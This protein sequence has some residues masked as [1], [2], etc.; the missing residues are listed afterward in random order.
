MKRLFVWGFVVAVIA[1]II[2]LISAAGQTRTAEPSPSGISTAAPVTVTT[3]ATQDVDE[4]F[5][6]IG[7]IAANNDVQVVSETQGRIVKVFASV[8]DHV[9][10]GAVLVEVDSE[11]REAAYK[12]ARA[13]YEKARKDLDRN[14]AL[15]KEGSIA[16]SQIEQIRWA[17]QSAEG[18]YIVARRQYND[19]KITSPIA[20]V[21]TARPVDIGVMAA[22]GAVVANVVDISR[23]K[24]KV[25]VPEKDAFR[26]TVGE[27]VQIVTDVYPGVSFA[28]TIATIGAKGD[29]AHT[30]P[31]E[32]S[33]G[34][35][36]E[37]PLKAGMFARVTFNSRGRRSIVVPRDAIIGGVRNARVYVVQNNVAKLRPVVVGDEVGT[38]IQILSGLKE[39]DLVVVNGQ[40]NLKDNVTVV[41]RR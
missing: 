37:Q 24:V 33:M 38:S 12:T 39:G 4:R 32:I 18:Q 27:K 36:K 20:G 6:L 8:G 5:I 22:P 23:L 15:Y 26:L 1:T 19:T 41:V 21:V 11:L 13:A 10:A 3:A 2:I 7:T 40:N 25:N 14:E 35:S 9:A 30:Y 17:F 16:D 28:G 34:N 29:D 31:V